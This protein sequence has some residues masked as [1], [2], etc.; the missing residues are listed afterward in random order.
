VLRDFGCRQ[1]C[2]KRI[3]FHVSKYPLTP[4]R[5]WNC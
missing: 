5:V 3:A 1:G 2:H 4:L